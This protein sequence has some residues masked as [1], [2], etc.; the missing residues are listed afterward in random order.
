[1]KLH[2]NT[3]IGFRDAIDGSLRLLQERYGVSRS[4]ARK[5]LAEAITRT[6]IWDEIIDMCDWQLGKETENDG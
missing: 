3:G 5:L 1:M 2:D 6:C 4:D